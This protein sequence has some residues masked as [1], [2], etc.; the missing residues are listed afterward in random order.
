M[1]AV[2]A[3]LLMVPFTLNSVG[4]GNTFHVPLTS[5]G[6]GGGRK[7]HAEPRSEAAAAVQLQ[8][9][10]G[11]ADPVLGAKR[12]ENRP[13]AFPPVARGGGRCSGRRSPQAVSWL[14]L[15]TVPTGQRGTI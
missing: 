6:G 2:E 14:L 12:S 7:R 5:G 13:L 9:G 10:F 4:L 8:V 11:S 15:V 1:T 3:S